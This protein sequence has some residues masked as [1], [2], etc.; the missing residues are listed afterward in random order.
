MASIAVSAGSTSALSGSALRIVT[1]DITLSSSYTTGGEA[2]SAAQV[3][4]GGITAAVATIKAPAGSTTE[5]YYDTSTGKLKCYTA[6]AEVANAVNLSAL[7]CEVVFFGK[8]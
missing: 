7:V 4:L 5:V 6:T 1:R 8:D 2:V 3:G